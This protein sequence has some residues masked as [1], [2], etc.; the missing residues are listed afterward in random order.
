M[1][2]EPIDL[3]AVRTKREAKKREETRQQLLRELRENGC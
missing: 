3:E 1:A 2:D